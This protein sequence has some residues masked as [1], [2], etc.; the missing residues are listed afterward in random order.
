VN[1]AHAYI[2]R[3]EYHR[4]ILLRHGCNLGRTHLLPHCVDTKKFGSL[5]PQYEQV[6]LFVGRL[7]SLKGVQYLLRAMKQVSVPSLV[8][9]VGDGNYRRQLEAVAPSV[10][11]RHLVQFTGWLEDR[12]LA[13]WYS[14]AR[15]VVM[16]SIWPE[17]F[18]LVGLEAMASTVPV[19]GFD[20]GGISSWLKDG[21][22]GF[23]VA[24]K[25]IGMLAERIEQLLG[26]KAQAAAMGRRG[27][28]MA[29]ELYTIE[30][31][32]SQLMR[33]YGG[34]VATEPLEARG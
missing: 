32:V 17:V 33:I 8:V 21:Q 19:I 12:G 30:G 31:H 26:D 20:V 18:G 25:E 29:E 10:P 28:E 2:V 15:V 34:L 24:P 4:R 13:Q 23:L 27:R 11:D 16:P 7:A 1:A 9:I 3:A 14:R 22:S 5:A 6:V